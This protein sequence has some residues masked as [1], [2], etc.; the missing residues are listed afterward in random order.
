MEELKPVYTPSQLNAEIK[1][2][3]RFS[4]GEVWVEGEISGF[5]VS[6]LDHYYFDLK[7]ENSI[8]SCVV[9]KWNTKNIDFEIKNG[10][11][12]R[13]CGE[14]T[15]FEKQSK[16]QLVIKKI[17]HIALGNLYIQFEK[18]K[19]K[20][21]KEGLFDE[22]R[23][24][25]IPSFPQNV[26]VITSLY[27]AAVRD[28]ISVIKRRAPHINI[29]IYP[30]KVQGEGAKEEISQ[31]IKD[32]NEHLPFVDVLLVGRGGGSMEDLWAFNEE[33]VA[34]A[35]ADS[36]IPV[37]SCVGHQIDFT[38]ADFVADLRAPTPSAAAEIVSKSSEEVILQIKQ[39]EKRLISTLKIVYHRLL[40]KFLRFINSHFYKNTN[41]LIEPYIINIDN[42]RERLIH[43]MDEK[44]MLCEAKV[45]KL[46]S[47][48]KNLNP[49]LPM[50]KG[51]AVVKKDNIVIKSV[52]DINV[53]E[54]IEVFVSDGNITSK[55]E[56]INKNPEEK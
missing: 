24:K 42:L 37:I 1:N 44:I 17:I 53:G 7:D 9:F 39:M 35:I 54:I 47:N 14:I 36:K 26:G 21:M 48:L 40:S 8:I 22:S 11:F 25:K 5:K 52:K 18:L 51:Y 30:V 46:A 20:L 16:Y 43:C 33:I 32:F 19:E 15:I 49:L 6:S 13:V 27:G 3:L 55:V 4:F 2:I 38:I 56:K 34:R 29:I 31:A 23:K 50:R 28:I 12:V 41:A 45:E 10:L